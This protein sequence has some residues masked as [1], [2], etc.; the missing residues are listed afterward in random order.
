MKTELKNEKCVNTEIKN[1]IKDVLQCNE[2]ECTALEAL[3][4]E[5]LL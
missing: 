2:N 3:V 1:E 4:F 5:N